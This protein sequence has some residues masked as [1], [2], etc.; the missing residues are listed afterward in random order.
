M[1]HLGQ[2]DDDAESVLDLYVPVEEPPVRLADGIGVHACLTGQG[3]HL[4][5]GFQHVA[6][7]VVKLV[8][9]FV[10]TPLGT[11]DRSVPSGPESATL[12]VPCLH[13]SCMSLYICSL[14][15][16]KPQAV[17]AGPNYYLIRFPYDSLSESSDVHGMHSA[18]QPDG[19]TSVYPD[20]RSGL[21][22][23]AVE[24]WGWLTGMVFWEAGDSSEYRA[25]FVRDPLGIF[26]APDSTATTDDPPT[27]GGQYRHYSHEIFVKPKVPLGLMVRHSA[28]SPL[29]ITLAEFKL[30]IESDIAS[31]AT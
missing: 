5:E 9:E 6:A 17:P 4:E 19:G 12:T 8:A 29:D 10:H 2:Q 11:S 18:A 27:P 13:A 15:V 30:A 3:G 24:G 28:A 21:I 16:E 1:S 26:G 22:W 20:A 25:R 14:K 31:P 7:A 23:P